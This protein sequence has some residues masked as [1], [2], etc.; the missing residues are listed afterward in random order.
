MILAKKVRI[1]PTKEQEKQLW[2]SVG[3]SRW[4]YNWAI[5]RQ[6]ETYQKGLKFLPDG[7]LRKEITQIKKQ[8]E[9]KWLGEVSNNVAKQAVKDACD[10]YKKF[11]KG[12]AN[13]PSFRSRK[14]SKPSFYN[15][16]DKL[17]VKEKMVLIEKVGWIKTSEQLPIG[18]KYMNPRVTYDNKYWY[19][20]VAIETED[21]I[22]ELNDQ[23]L[24]VDLGIKDLAICSDG[25]IFKNINKRN[26]VKKIEKRLRRL[27]RSVSRKY[28]MN[29]EGNRFVKTSNIIKNEKRIQH[30]YRRL[31]NIRNNYI[32]QS[33]NDVV[34]TKPRRV[35]I[36]DLN[37]TGL[38]KNRH[39]AKALAKQKLYE[40]IRQMKYK[41]E[42]HGI[43]FIQVSRFYP[44]SK[45]CSDCGNI[46][47][48]LKLSDRTYKCGCGLEIDRDLNAAL[49]L[50]R[51]GEL[52][53]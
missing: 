23:V 34:K 17:R 47:K 29:K 3:T 37:V 4:V 16:N 5:S 10:A 49:N 43:E 20:S 41:C 24:G 51:Y 40:F 26:E 53:A 38:M 32:H 35:V 45:T 27:Q 14:K 25:R 48:D 36:E 31:A 18:V 42:K 33:T 7:V 19:L 6:Q 28:A 8:D 21:V 11:F 46:K 15:A 12:L 9:F 52:M 1:K 13:R 50:K 39:L 44:S 2:K 30:L 22:Q